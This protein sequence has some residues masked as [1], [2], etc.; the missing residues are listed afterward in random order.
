MKNMAALLASVIIP[1]YNGE[2]YLAEALQSIL[3]Q[4]Y[5]PIDVIVVDDGS[6]DRSAAIVQQFSGV[7]YIYQSN[8]GVAVARNVG[9]AAAWGAIITFLDQ[10]DIWIPR[11]LEIQVQHLRQ[12][13]EVDGVVGKAERDLHFMAASKLR[14]TH[15]P[16]ISAIIPIYNGERYLAEAIQSALDQTY[17]VAEVIVVDDGSTDDAVLVAQQF[18]PPVRTI[19][20]PH[21]G[22]SAARNRGVQE[23]REEYLAFLDAD[24]IWL[25]DKLALQIA[26]FAANPAPDMVF[27]YVQQFHSPDLDPLLKARIVCPAE[28]AAGILPSTM[29]TSREAFL[30]VG[31]FDDT[32][33]TGELLD[34]YLRATELGLRT[35]MLPEVVLRRRLHA[36]NHGRVQRDSRK[37][38]ARVLKSALDRRRSG[39]G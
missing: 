14:S 12:H 7:R 6:T 34:W 21:A 1:V 39:N 24:D 25:P 3:D 28:P 10:N 26:A 17:A 18:P 30:R 8:Q 19:Q 13:P 15:R 36:G 23:S 38:F 32:V 20:Q 27:G 31:F 22:A 9:L 37:D 16:R 2:K 33:M 11:K 5:R 4:N 35:A 29:M